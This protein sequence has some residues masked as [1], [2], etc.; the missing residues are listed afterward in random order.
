MG[1]CPSPGPLRRPPP[2][3]GSP[4]PAPP[5]TFDSRTAVVVLFFFLS[6]AP[7]PLRFC[8]A[9]GRRLPS[10]ALRR[11]LTRPLT[12]KEGGSEGG[13]QFVMKLLFLTRIRA[14]GLWPVCAPLFFFFPSPN[15]DT[16]FFFFLPSPASAKY[17]MPLRFGR[18]RALPQLLLL[19]LASRARASR[20]HFPAGPSAG[21]WG[22]ARPARRATRCGW[23]S[24]PLPP[25][26]DAPGP[27]P[28]AV[29]RI[30][31][32]S[33]GSGAEGGGA[34]GKEEMRGKTTLSTQL[35]L[36]KS[37]LP[38]VPAQPVSREGSA[39]PRI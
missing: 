16:F 13:Q 23:E 7:S 3:A 8:S 14:R 36:A 24:R 22:L 37:S 20:L 34:A 31:S 21:F 30:R 15:P 11:S 4:T 28:K 2:A 38:A 26:R 29:G 18:L 35:L 6:P 32:L 9:R 19:S 12:G 33:L 25:S 17:R 27:A 39:A 5:P 10:S 1:E